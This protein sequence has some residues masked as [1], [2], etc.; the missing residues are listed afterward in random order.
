MRTGQGRRRIRAWSDQ[1]PTT[2]PVYPPGGRVTRVLSLPG[3]GVDSGFQ[4]LARDRHG[5]VWYANRAGLFRIGADG[6]ATRVGPVQPMLALR[7]DR[8]GRT[9]AGGDG[10][11]YLLRNGDSLQQVWPQAMEGNGATRV[12]SIAEAPDGSLWLSIAGAGL[13]RFDPQTGAARALRQRA[14][15]MSRLTDRRNRCNISSSLSLL[16]ER[17]MHRDTA[18]EQHAPCPRATKTRL[19]RPVAPASWPRSWWGS[20]KRHAAMGCPRNARDKRGA[21]L[22]YRRKRG[23]ER[24]PLDCS[25]IAAAWC[26]AVL[27]LG[28][29]PR[30]ALLER[31]SR[32]PLNRAHAH[33]R[34]LSGAGPCFPL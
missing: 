11:L 1:R 33:L 22:Q 20:W 4:G 2:G 27:I 12:Q 34:R 28:A 10:G 23:A 9:W 16:R 30:F 25:R 26:P 32:A 5:D 19:C 7:I 21:E 15:V 29:L 3:R 18:R 24:L 31:R 17:R 6:R 8:A 14:P 13:R